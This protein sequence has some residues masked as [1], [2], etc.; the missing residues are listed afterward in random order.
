MFTRQWMFQADGPRAAILIRLL[1]GAVFFSEGVQK[2]LFPQALG[3]GRF[4]QIGIPAP[5][6]MAPFVGVVEVVCG[7]LL[8]A[9]LI[10]RLAAIPLLID[11]TVA[12]LST[13]LPLLLGKG[14]WAAA[15]EA[16]T[17]FCMLLGLIFVL[18]VGGGPLSVDRRLAP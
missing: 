7:A 1:T 11:I 9:G 15:H 18:W 2:F 17:D 3:A 13:K 14:F 6:V 8:V 4:L 10:T 12:I 5:H 16:R